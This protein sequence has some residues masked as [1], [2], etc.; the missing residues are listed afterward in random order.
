M[1][2]KLIMMALGAVILFTACDLNDPIYNT[3]HP[4]HGQIVKLTTDWTGIGT[5]ISVPPICI[6]KVGGYSAELRGETKTI[7]NLFAPGVYSVCIHNVADKVS[8]SGTLAEANYPAG[9]SLR[10]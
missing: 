3:P 10:P 9:C 1:A 8:V 4:E 6:V 5:G 2:K 7:G